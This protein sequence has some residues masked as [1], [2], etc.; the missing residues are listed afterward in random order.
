MAC[1]VKR[2]LA[3]V[4]ALADGFSGLPKAVFAL[5]CSLIAIL[6]VHLHKFE[7]VVTGTSIDDE[8]VIVARKSLATS[9]KA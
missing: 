2:W 7:R 3:G 9:C 8:K 1:N 6:C 4:H 5:M